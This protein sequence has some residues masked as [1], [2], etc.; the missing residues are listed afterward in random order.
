MSISSYSNAIMSLNFLK[1]IFNLY[2]DGFCISASCI[3]TANSSR[4]SRADTGI[5]ML[6]AKSLFQF[7]HIKPR[8][9]SKW[10]HAPPKGVSKLLIKVC[11]SY[12]QRCLFGPPNY[13]LRCPHFSMGSYRSS[14]A[15]F[16]ARLRS[17]E[18]HC[19]IGDV[20]VSQVSWQ[21]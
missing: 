2:I 1:F 16:K 5:F 15:A 3:R 12:F 4:F 9:D 18:G 6:C 8:S 13:T 7:T 19:V 10:H 14:D 11:V 20:I 21:E 17:L